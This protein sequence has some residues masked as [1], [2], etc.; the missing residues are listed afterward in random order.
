MSGAR[1]F[2]FNPS[3]R[4]WTAPVAPNTDAVL[5]FHQSLPN[6]QPTNLVS[7]DEVARELG[8]KS[9]VV[10]DETSRLG[11]PSFKILGASWGTFRALLRELRLPETATFEEVKKQLEGTPVK[12]HA[13]T[14]GNHGRAVARM[15]SLLAIPA[16]IHV[17]RQMSSQTIE[18]IKSEGARVISSN[19]SYEDAIAAAHARADADEHGILVQDTAFEGYEEIPGWIVEGYATMLREIDEQLGDEHVD[20]VICPVGV[21]S[22]ALSVLTHFKRENRRTAMLA[23]EPDTAACLWTSVARGEWTAIETTPTIMAGLDCGQV[24]TT[25]WPLLRD[26]VDACLTVS[27]YEAHM[28]LVGL[29]TAGVHAGPCGGSPLA[30]LRRGLDET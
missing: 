30:A 24:S 14:D 9:V 3:A 4:S 21:G 7:L 19:G 13:A 27:D 10:K 5:T 11:L 29:K 1:Q 25:A 8:V 2:N 16:E 26:G 22:L 28:A 23:V 17:P 15:G 18:L 20:L 6:Y 12:L